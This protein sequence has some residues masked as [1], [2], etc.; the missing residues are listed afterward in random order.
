MW[1]SHITG[2]KHLHSFW[3]NYG[4]VANN[5]DDGTIGLLLFGGKGDFAM[6]D[7]SGICNKSI[8]KLSKNE[9]ESIL[10]METGPLQG[11]TKDSFLFSGNHDHNVH[12]LT[13]VTKHSCVFLQPKRALYQPSWSW[14]I[15]TLQ[16]LTTVCQS[17]YFDETAFFQGQKTSQ[18]Q[19]QV[20]V[21]EVHC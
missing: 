21:G 17:W 2:G 16:H 18:N 19:L 13:P 9:T 5:L 8:Y 6:V 7:S 14:C 20:L 4:N 11:A 1:Q 3:C 10:D 12:S 15:L